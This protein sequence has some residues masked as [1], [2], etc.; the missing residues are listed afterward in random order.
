[1]MLQG[2]SLHV[3]LAPSYKRN[4]LFKAWLF[5]RGITAPMFMLLSGFSFSIATHKRWEQHTQLASTARRVRR[6]AFFLCLG[7]AI[8]L[9]VGM[10]SKL[11]R[12][13]ATLVNHFLNVD[14]LQ[15][16]AVTLTSLQLLVMLSRRPSRFAWTCGLTA[17]TIALA[18][19]MVRAVSWKETIWPPLAAYLYGGTGSLF[20]LFG[21]SAFIL[22][23]AALGSAFMQHQPISNK[24]LSGAFALVGVFAVGV[25]RVLDYLAGK[26]YYEHV[27]PEAKPRFLIK[28]FGGAMIILSGFVRLSRH[29]ERL[30]APMQ[31]LAEES[32]VVYLV[33]LCLLY[34]SVWGPG[35]RQLVGAHLG[36]SATFGMIIGLLVAMTLLAYYWNRFKKGYPTGTQLARLG[37]AIALVLPIL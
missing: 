22:A 37:I 8:H 9:P 29:T 3:L 11:A 21:W 10:L 7:Y 6:F 28:R 31:A 25:A 26:L 12:L 17:L 24:R 13:D 34:G 19:P 35:M 27:V 14:V 33:H 16:I 4:K 15:L 23:G 20:P 36:P 30:P 32:L 2:H 1:M 5:V 18:T